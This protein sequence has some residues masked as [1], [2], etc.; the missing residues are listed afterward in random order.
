MSMKLPNLAMEYAS[1]ANVYIALSQR[2]E[3]PSDKRSLLRADIIIS[4]YLLS[5]IEL[6]CLPI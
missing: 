6:H 4:P 2:V 1:E 3:Q 5:C